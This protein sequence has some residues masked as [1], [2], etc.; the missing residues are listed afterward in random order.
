MDGASLA[1]D[2]CMRSITKARLL[3]TAV[4]VLVPVPVLA[5]GYVTPW[6]GY[7]V[8]GKND[9]GRGA[10]GAVAGYMGAGVFGFE[11]DF[12]YM[13]DFFGSRREF[14]SN[15]AISAMGNF[16]LGVPIGG[17]HG[18]GVRPFVSGGVGLMRTHIEG[19]A[20]LDASRTNNA[21]G[22][23]IGAGMMGFFNQHIGLRGDVRYTRTLDDTDRGSGV[24]LD[25]G[26]L[27]YWRV[28]GGV[29]FR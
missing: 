20:L 3:W 9:P 2:V 26:R 1:A 18:A 19:G 21:F 27:R 6:V 10:F 5:D 14:G 25:P 12:E 7:S 4:V 23:N 11:A 13:P 15:N 17:T 29:T 28:S 22:Y 24:D 16:I 8:T